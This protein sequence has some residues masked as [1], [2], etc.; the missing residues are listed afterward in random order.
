MDIADRTGPV[1][2]GHAFADSIDQWHYATT[3]AYTVDV[4]FARGVGQNATALQR[5]G[6]RFRT[7]DSA[8]LGVASPVMV[9]VTGMVCVF[10][11]NFALKDA[12]GSHACSLEALPCV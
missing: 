12:I 4:D 7:M 11:Q 10:E 5:H 1:S 3:P 2:G 8:V 6:A 9:G